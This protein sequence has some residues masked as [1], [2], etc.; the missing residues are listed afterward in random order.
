MTKD[1]DQRP[2]VGNTYCDAIKAMEDNMYRGLCYL[3]G[4]ISGLS[5]QEARYWRK[6]AAQVLGSKYGIITRDPTRTEAPPFH[7]SRGI[8]ARDLNDV[9]QS[10]VLLVNLLSATTLSIGTIMELAWAYLLQKPAVVI[11]EDSGNIHDRHPMLNEA[12]SFRVSTLEAGIKA[13]AIILG[14]TTKGYDV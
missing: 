5:E 11:I 8:I 4:G 14:E 9:K 1:M 12:M 6:S 2:F 7:T 10:D 3:A 13:V